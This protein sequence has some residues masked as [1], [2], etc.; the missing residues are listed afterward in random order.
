MGLYKNKAGMERKGG[1]LHQLKNISDRKKEEA[2]FFLQCDLMLRIYSSKLPR[3]R[4]SFYRNQTDIVYKHFRLYTH[5]TV[6]MYCA[7]NRN[8]GLVA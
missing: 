4:I 2:I 3:D 6:Q 1:I 5:H 7:V 8:Y